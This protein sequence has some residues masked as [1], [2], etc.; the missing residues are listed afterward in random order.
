[1][2]ERYMDKHAMNHHKLLTNAAKRKGNDM[3]CNLL[4]SLALY[5]LR[6]GW[7]TP[8]ERLSFTFFSELFQT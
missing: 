7:Y 3:H 5:V 6:T 2:L 8:M 4:T 1:M